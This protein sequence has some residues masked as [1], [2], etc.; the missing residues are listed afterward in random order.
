MEWPI[1]LESS[2]PMTEVLCD[3]TGKQVWL[4]QCSNL[5]C[6]TKFA[7]YYWKHVCA[8]FPEVN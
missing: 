6:K 3:S 7:T 1:I 4:C 5:F 8:R 2:V